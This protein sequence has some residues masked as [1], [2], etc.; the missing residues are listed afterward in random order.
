MRQDI[1]DFYFW[2][3]SSRLL[4]GFFLYPWQQTALY[5]TVS[6][7]R[8]N[9]DA[10]I[11][12]KMPILLLLN[13]AFHSPFCSFIFLFHKSQMEPL[14]FPPFQPTS[15]PW[16]SEAMEGNHLQCYCQCRY[17]RGSLSLENSH[18]SVSSIMGETPLSWLQIPVV[19]TS[20][21]E[22]LTPC[23]RLKPWRETGTGRHCLPQVR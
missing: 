6:P 10:E 21:S 3:S 22:L 2:T 18:P 4:M 14:L 9:Q 19:G 8:A 13:L 11:E 7:Q 5:A 15:L 16:H 20:I 12:S 1:K 23:S 17:S